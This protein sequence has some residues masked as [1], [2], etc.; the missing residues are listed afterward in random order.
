[1][2]DMDRFSE[3][4]GGGAVYFINDYEKFTFPSLSITLFSYP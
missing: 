4:L 3:E 2:D 1:M